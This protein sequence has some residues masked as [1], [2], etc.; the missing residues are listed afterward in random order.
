VIRTTAILFALGAVACNG[1]GDGGAAD[2]G[3]ADAA[4]ADGAP[5]ASP[6]APG[7][8][9][10][11]FARYRTRVA[12]LVE[13]S[14]DHDWGDGEAVAGSGADRFSARFTATLEVPEA[15][16]Y[17][18]ATNADD[19]VRLW[20]GDELVIDD[21]RPHYPERHDGTVEL[22]A[23]PVAIRLDYFEIDLTAELH[24]YWTRPGAAEQLLDSSHVTSGAATDDGPKPPYANPVV[25]F[26]CPDPGV[27]A[28]GDP[29]VYYAICT[30]GSFPIRRSYDLVLWEETGAEVLPSGV[31]PWSA[32]GYRNWAPEMHRV[33]DR[34]VVYYTAVNGNDVLSIGAASSDAPTGPFVDRGGPLVEHPQGVIDA[35]FFRDRDGKQYL[36][37]KIDGN[38]VGAPT[39]I[40]LREL[41]A[42]GLSF[43]AG[44]VEVELIRNAPATWEGGVVEAPWLIEH[45]GSYYLFYSGN[46][47]DYRY[48]TG[49]ARASAVAGP[50]SKRGAPILANDASWVGPGHGSVVPAGDRLYFVYHAWRANGSGQH[51]PA[52]G[53]NILVD[54][55]TFADG[56]PQ[57][58]DGTP[59]EGLRPWPVK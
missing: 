44:S 23:G 48:R 46:V 11:Y 55:I 42:D 57:I 36:L 9:A 6:P 10:D 4:A 33:G 21:W 13:P 24:L 16:S 56:W 14:I 45:D 51:D 31:A 18:F 53:R 17:R 40:Y 2:G 25:A 38:S 37:Y 19:G 27:I 47:Y 52:Y 7:F 26:D 1:A 54:E 32:N 8:R 20:V 34:Y 3:A 30:G 15:G 39:P 22:A 50:Y 29:P 28:A 5:D 41:A 59:S 43:A 58:H 49:V 12:S 35:S